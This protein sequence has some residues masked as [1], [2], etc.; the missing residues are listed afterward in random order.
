MSYPSITV[1]AAA[2]TGA[3]ATLVGTDLCGSVTITTGTG[4]GSGTLF[5]I[6]L[7]GSL[8]TVSASFMLM[9]ANAGTESL[10]QYLNPNAIPPLVVS[11]TTGSNIADNT[12]YKLC[13]KVN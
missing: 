8:V 7:A 13:Y 9:A 1:G 4:T 12:T 11:V 3:T 10:M 6:T 2:G 5:T